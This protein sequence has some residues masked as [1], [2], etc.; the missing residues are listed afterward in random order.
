MGEKELNILLGTVRDNIISRLTKA[1][2]SNKPIPIWTKPWKTIYPINFFTGAKYTGINMVYFALMGEVKGW[3]SP[4]F[5]TYKQCQA[6]NE[7]FG[8][9]IHVRAK[10]SHIKGM[11]VIDNWVPS[12]WKEIKPETFQSEKTGDIKNISEVKRQLL[13]PFQVFNAQQIENCP[14]KFLNE[15]KEPERIDVDKFVQAQKANIKDAPSA[16]FN[17]SQDYIGMP[18][19]SLFKTEEDYWATNLHEHGHWTGHKTRLGRDLTG[20][21]GSKEYAKEELVAEMTSAFL[22]AYFGMK[23]GL[24]HTSYIGHYLSILKDDLNILRD[25]TKQATKAFTFLME[26]ATA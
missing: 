9:N 5:I 1:K 20:T 14:E 6:F 26:N 10:E 18:P 15:E 24:Q 16:F 23:S 4:Y 22:C 8:T 21:Q 13:R 19:L 3:S 12:E 2:D 7:K 11:R 25:M 17:P